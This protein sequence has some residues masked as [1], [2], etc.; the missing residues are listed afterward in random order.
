MSNKKITRQLSIYINGKE[1]KNSLGGIGREIAKVKAKLK[2]ANDPKDITKHKEELNLLRKKYS[3]VKDEIHDSNTALQQA[4]EHWDMLFSGILSGNIKQ[5]QSGLKGILGN[6]KNITKAAIAFIATPLGAAIAAITTIGIGVKSWVEFN[7]EVEKTN[8]L[9]RDLTQET[10]RA[11]DGIRIR[12]EILQKTF[13]VDIGK[14]VET[15]KSLVKGFNISYSEAFDIIEEGA[16]KGKLKNDEYL[17]S[18]KEYP[19][20]FKNAGFSAKDFANIVSTGIDLSIYSDKLPDAIKEFNLSI[21]EQTD[22]AK[23]ALTNAFGEKFTSK[24]FKGL[25][26]GSVN[27]KDALATISAE[28]Q[29][30]GLN[31][32]QAQLL[33]ADLFK[34]AG[35]DAGGALKIFEAV[36]L[37]LN[38][39]KKPL[40]EIQKIQ[41]E[42]LDTN[43]ELN[44][45]YTQL[46][47]SGSSG[48]NMWIQ[49]GKLFASQ[50]LLKILKGG[51]DVYNWFVDL[52]NESATFSAIL[53]TLG[54]LFTNQFSIIGDVL[55]LAWNQ[56]K[57]FGTLVEG[58]F[59]L[60][61]NK[62]K[63]AFNS[64]LE[65]ISNAL[66]KLKKRALNDA[67]EIYNAWN[68]N[69]KLKKLT[70]DD[71]LSKEPT[72]NT[73]NNSTTNNPDEEN[74]NELTEE[75]KRIIE[76][77]KKLKEFLDQWKKDQALQKEL[78]K[79]D[80][81]AKA[82]EEEILKLE[83]K[84]AKME[85]EAGILGLKEEELTK[86]GRIKD[87]ELRKSL[88]E[89]KE[90]EISNIRK[91]YADKRLKAK[92]V[93]LKKIADK[94]KKYKQQ[95]LK[96][97]QD[98]ENAKMDLLKFGISNLKNFFDESKGLYK[99]FFIAEKV[100]AGVDV[101]LKGI[102]ERASISAAWG[103]NPAI[104]G[105]ML[106]ASKIRTGI[107]LATIAG[108]AIK[109]FKEGGF[110]GD[111]A[112]YNDGQDGV[113]GPAHVGEWY[114]PKWMNE[115][116]KYAPIIQWLEK[117]RTGTTHKGFFE[118]GPT[119]P[120]TID[121]SNE[122]LELSTIKISNNDE[123]IQLLSNLKTT[124][125]QG[126]K[127]YVVRDYDQFVKEKEVDEEYQQILNN[128]RQ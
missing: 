104:S 2:E 58:I 26:N 20:Q 90:I 119:S 5:V 114:A 37:A 123:L 30:I 82:E 85:E 35:E 96:A 84:L 29:R 124:L 16:I 87:A 11:V 118:G 112:I 88:E 99:A 111:K 23:E 18:L 105:P 28:A 91:K 116:P 64:G 70:L 34:G 45:V 115:S 79:F 73:F 12:A 106:L 54:I 52:N 93:E 61:P 42:Q 97:E 21:T 95:Q 113:V 110:T 17:N 38:E 78:E 75:D 13:E 67:D 92:E 72:G 56:F 40:T 77:K 109:G 50:T 48:F 31:S 76:S 69:S 62:I 126:I 80:E 14:S 100:V 1:V 86:A 125:D 121:E 65:N 6:L 63:D 8:Q 83:A 7:L 66:T 49:K 53:K 127:A 22:A 19:I 41:K 4:N 102:K 51:V 71:L 3:E 122:S 128:T 27:A 44:S 25:K 68:G 107:N 32:Q 89:T 10:G 43:K 36:N 74:K 46:F 39:Q 33:T 24:L 59:T 57:S 117:E 108:T 60:N 101:V 9:V 98:L 15:A 120:G 47:A 55:S 94:E 81:E 103:W